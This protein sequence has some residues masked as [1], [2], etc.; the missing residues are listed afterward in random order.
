METQK[1][2]FKDEKSSENVMTFENAEEISNFLETF[3]LENGEVIELGDAMYTVKNVSKNEN[4][5]SVE[6]EYMDLIEN[7][8]T[9]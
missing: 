1:I 6:V 5:T 8:P 7:K 9:A 2:I 3:K 4:E